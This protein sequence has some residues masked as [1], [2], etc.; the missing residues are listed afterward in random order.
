MSQ[1][2]PWEDNRVKEEGDGGVGGENVASV[3]EVLFFMAET[4]LE[5][6]L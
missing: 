5:T 4:Q 2:C 3:K 1:H 6:R